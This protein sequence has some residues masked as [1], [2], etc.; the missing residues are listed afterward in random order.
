MSEADVERT[1]VT[2]VPVQATLTSNVLDRIVVDPVE[3]ER[4]PSHRIEPGPTPSA[5]K[6]ASPQPQPLLPQQP[7][8]K[9]T[10]THP[11]THPRVPR[12]L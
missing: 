5:R 6:P 11:P 1:D 12:D 8:R 4:E 3:L 7:P 9:K 2:T 10:Q